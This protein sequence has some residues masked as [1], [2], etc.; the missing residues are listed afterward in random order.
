MTGSVAEWAKGQGVSRQM[1]Y[2]RLASAGVPVV[3]GRVDFAV[4]DA[5]WARVVNPLQQQRSQHQRA[6]Q[7]RQAAAE[8]AREAPAAPLQTTA[9]PPPASAR[10]AMPPL[11]TISAA[12]LRRELVRIE[13]E[14]LKLAQEKKLLV[15]LAE[16]ESAWTDVG[17]RLKNA[18]LSIPAQMVNRL[19]AEWRR[20]VLT[21][22]TD[23][24]RKVLDSLSNEI[25]SDPKAA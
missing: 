4:A 7:E 17:V 16:V 22:A 14:S 10:R 20:D 21:A 23:E 15:P 19:P 6:A 25:R 1:G 2:R 24:V 3:G 13:R 5:A 9:I 12:Q 8:P 11:T 18:V